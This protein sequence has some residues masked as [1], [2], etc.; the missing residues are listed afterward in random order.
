[1]GALMMATAEDH[2]ARGPYTYPVPPVDGWKAEDLDTI[3]GLPPHTELIDGGLFYVSPQ[4]DFHMA[5]LRWLES[6]LWNQAPDELYVAREMTVRL[7]PRDRVEPDLMAV[8]RSERT[9]VRQTWYEPSAVRLAVE[10]VSPESAVRDRGVKPRKY[11]EAGIPH[12]WRVEENEGLPVVYVHELDPVTKT[13]AVNGIF[14]GKLAV[15]LPFPITVDLA[16][17]RF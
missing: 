14:H 13:Y 11:A 7:S 1:M 2:N 8:L 3:P 6:A 10:I 15:D 5:V 9:S 16:G 12:F 4:A 17:M